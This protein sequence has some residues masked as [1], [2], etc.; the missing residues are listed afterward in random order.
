MYCSSA[1][2][3]FYRILHDL[4]RDGMESSPRGMNIKE[5]L[6]Y[7]ITIDNPLNNVVWLPE[8]KISPKYLVAELFWYLLAD[9]TKDGADFICNHAK[10]WDSL[11]NEDGSLNSNYGYYIFNKM[12]DVTKLSKA[13]DFYKKS[14]QLDYVVNI[15]SNDKDSRQA[16]ININNITHKNTATK[17]FPCTTAIQFFI[18][19]DAL[20]MVVTMRSCDVVLGFCNDVYQFTSI[21]TILYN[22]LKRVYPELK[23]GFYTLFAGSMH[24]YE[25]HYGMM[26][27]ILNNDDYKIN[28][29]K[30]YT[31]P[32]SKYS[33]KLN[34]SD[35]KFIK[36][37]FKDPSKSNK[38]S[39]VMTD[40][41]SVYYW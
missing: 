13:S 19:K 33:A 12:K 16:V 3:A 21:Q 38:C 14:S 5:L 26:N 39:K 28:G 24:I 10:F 18:R 6:S 41:L 40:L 37:Y 27:C 1:S 25:R 35:V 7:C 30:E 32:L 31:K 2:E 29:F 11:R 36:N 20:H 15:L 22:K 17:D 4:R 9:Q 8:R 23:M 34:L